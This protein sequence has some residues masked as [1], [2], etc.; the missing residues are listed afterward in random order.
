MNISI[1]K[2]NR[3]EYG[4]EKS[5][6]IVS[7]T[8]SL[9]TKNTAKLK[10]Y[11]IKGIEIIEI[12]LSEYKLAG[13]IYSL[14]VKGLPEEGFQYEYESD[15]GIISDPYIKA[16]SLNR[17]YDHE[18]KKEDVSRAVFRNVAYDWEGDAH[19]QLDYS[20][21]ISYQLHVRG[22]T[23]HSSSRVKAN[24]TFS[25]IV[26]KIPYLKE[27]GIN[28]LIL[29]PSY[30]FYEID[31]ELDNKAENHPSFITDT[32]LDEKGNVIKNEPV[33]KINYWGFKKAL[34]FMPKYTYCYTKQPEIEFKDMVKALHNA[35]IEVIMQMFF[36]KNESERLISDSLRFWYIE[37][38]VDGFHVMGESIPVNMIVNDPL[39]S[40]AKIY[41][42]DFARYAD[43]LN[44]SSCKYVIDVNSGFMNSVRSFLKSDGNSLM[45]FVNHDRN[46]PNRPYSVNYITCYEGFTLN[47][48]VS[49]EHKHNE[50][51]GEN[52]TD[53]T[54]YNLSWN[55]GSEGKSAKKA[56]K[57]LRIRQIKN[58]LSMLILSQG[59]PMLRMGDEI[60]N[61]Q[62]GNNNPYCQ[63]NELSWINWKQNKSKDEIFEF[64]KSLIQLRKEH[65]VFHQDIQLKGMDY[66]SCGNPDISYHQDMAW[67]TEFNSYFL[68]LGKML[69]GEYVIKDGESDETFY[70][71][72]NMHWDNHIFGLPRLKDMKWEYVTGTC[73][74]LEEEDIKKNLSDSQDN[75]NVYKRSVIILKAVKDE[76][77]KVNKT[78]SKYK[79]KTFKE[80]K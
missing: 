28:Q 27:L 67:K 8:I 57:E 56:I 11:S 72:Y 52:N 37:Y 50:K 40:E 49:Y 42:N 66:L 60:M 30:E 36:V 46:N 3:T 77:I 12:D 38:H 6:E 16:Q 53:G 79:K 64:T 17:A 63:D 55:C 13:N 80:E 34:Y 58:A 21:V 41:I 78:A 47:D 59:T 5:G 7:F 73:S 71:A 15:K 31:S 70:I 1:S 51:N 48:L 4:V 35:G 75:F 10:I 22:F 25:G 43:S 18:I 74:N 45:G 26:E 65:K 62:D 24:G 2:S 32:T 14:S 68:H 33:K 23:K 61:S 44:D 76:S 19:L 54:D 9:D 20:E 69:N 39:L 29:M